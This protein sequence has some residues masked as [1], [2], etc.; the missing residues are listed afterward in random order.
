MQCPQCQLEMRPRPTSTGIE[1]DVCGDCGAVRFD[2]GEL[3][4]VS[5]DDVAV[6]KAIAAAREVSTSTGDVVTASLGEGVEVL[7]D[8]RDGGVFVPGAAIERLTADG[9]ITLR[10]Q[11]PERTTPL[12]FRV[13]RL[14]LRSVATVILLYAV[15]GLAVWMATDGQPWFVVAGGTFAGVGTGFLL[16]PWLID[17]S[18]RWFYN[19][20]RRELGELPSHLR[21]F[22][23]DVCGRY[24]MTVPKIWLI[25]DGAPTAFTYGWSPSTARVVF[26][27]GLVEVLE[28]RELEAVIGHEL[29]HARY[30]DI[31]VM[32]LAELP[33]VGLQWAYDK[34]REE[35]NERGL[36]A[37][38]ATLVYM[39]ALVSEYMTLWLSRT[40]EYH[41]D[42]FGAL[43]VQSGNAMASALV[44][45]AYGLA[46]RPV[47]TPTGNGAPQS[48][49]LGVFDR[50][51][52]ATLAITSTRRTTAL[53]KHDFSVED[54]QGAMKWDLWNPWALVS[55][56]HS[57]HPLVAKRLLHMATISK[58]L[59]EVPLIAFD[60]P[61]PESYWDEFAVDLVIQCLPW[62]G[63][64]AAAVGWMYASW[65]GLGLGL[66]GCAAG[67]AVRL[68]SRY[69]A[70]VFAELSVATLLRQVKVSDIRGIPCRLGGVVRGKGE[71]GL[72]WS[73]D[74]V[75]HDDTGMMFLDHRQPFAI[76]EI[77]WGWLASWKV[78]GGQ[79]VVEGWFR[80][81]PVPYVEIAR[82]WVDGELR[83]S[84]YRHFRWFGVSLVAV[85]GVA[86]IVKGTLGS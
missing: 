62:I 47:A 6:A 56:L 65:L 18:L 30:W 34:L 72:V 23:E 57:T 36:K 66:L 42:R 63:V 26:S 29:G 76:W 9:A 73:E 43:A 17:M 55:E 37:T 78:I 27:T 24:S 48:R 28:P 74:F 51:A 4:L 41:A 7:F 44:K 40:R 46:A 16:A 86:A 33:A 8:R 83:R 71:P 60:L 11:D 53:G 58:E 38:A 2:R 39:A 81:A 12:R 31:A 64:G 45:I 85:A 13:P 52:A 35:D 19:A 15:A 77:L 25:E 5:R 82:Y 67:L 32:T 20:K 75:L 49:A 14:G 22:I 50:R 68:W 10:W 59:G 54:V 69:R 61:K 70:S 84:W 3:L 1:L 80:R 21:T 79:M